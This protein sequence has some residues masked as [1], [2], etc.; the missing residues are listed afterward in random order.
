MAGVLSQKVIKKA[1]KNLATSN[2]IPND[3]PNIASR[4]FRKFVFNEK[5]RRKKVE[6][7]GQAF[8]LANLGSGTANM[9]LGPNGTTMTVEKTEP[10]LTVTASGTVGTFAAQSEYLYPMNGNLGWLQ[11]MANSF[12]SYEVLALEVTYI[13]SVP[14]TA[15]GAVSMSFYEDLSDDIPT[16]MSQMLVSEQSL[17]AP[18]YAGGEGGRYLQRFGSPDGNI[19]S[20]MLPKH[21]YLDAKGTPKRFK[22]TKP[23]TVADVAADTAGFAALSNY[24]VGRLVVATEGC[25]TS[26]QKVGQVF[27]RYKLRLSGTVAIGNQQ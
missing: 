23:V 10:L 8:T 1:I 5:N 22:I 15:T 27:L 9:S 4:E 19:V 14:T 20:F 7:G 13:P 24:I 17:Y 16:T 11:N 21:C 6:I 26:S 18:I 25:A 2:K 3:L 12:T